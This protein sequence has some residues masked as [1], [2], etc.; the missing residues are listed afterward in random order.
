MKNT[1]PKTCGK[2][3]KRTYQNQALLKYNWKAKVSFLPA[4]WKVSVEFAFK[5]Q[6]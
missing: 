3:I 6:Q 4:K 5:K 2:T 1:L